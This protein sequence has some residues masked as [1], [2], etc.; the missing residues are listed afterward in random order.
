MLHSVTSSSTLDRS[1]GGTCDPPSSRPKARTRERSNSGMERRVETARFRDE[2]DLSGD[3]RVG[4]RSDRTRRETGRPET[5][6]TTEVARRP[7]APDAKRRAW[8]G[9][10]PDEPG[11]APLAFRVVVTPGP[12][13]PSSVLR[14]RA[15]RSRRCQR[16]RPIE[17]SLALRRFGCLRLHRGRWSR[18]DFGRPT[19]RPRLGRRRASTSAFLEVVRE[20]ETSPLT[21]PGCWHAETPLVLDATGPPSGGFQG[22]GWSSPTPFVL[23]GEPRPRRIGK[24]G[25]ST[26]TSW[27]DARGDVPTPRASA[28]L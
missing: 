18:R 9:A 12:R 23:P 5:D 16:N 3:P 26:W 7:S 2:V 27:C 15:A 8:C 11:D 6:A 13:G 28:I 20:E 4:R 14:V 22:P 24:P 10:S 25:G 19:P 1:G 17:S 21:D